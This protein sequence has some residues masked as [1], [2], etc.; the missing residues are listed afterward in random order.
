M[1]RVEKARALLVN[2][3]M[4]IGLLQTVA[5]TLTSLPSP[6]DSRNTVC[7]RAHTQNV[8]KP[9]KRTCRTKKRI[10]TMLSTQRRYTL[11]HEYYYAYKVF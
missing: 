7:R 2:T 4:P 6:E 10:C 5:V 9:D 8:Q 3:D 11:T 1:L